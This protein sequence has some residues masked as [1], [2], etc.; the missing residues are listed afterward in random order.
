M[1][2]FFQFEL[3][4]AT[5]RIQQTSCICKAGLWHC[6]H[7]IGLF[8]TLAHYSQLVC[9]SVTKTKYKTSLPQ[10]WHVHSRVLGINPK[11]ATLLKIDK[12]KPPKL[13]HWIKDLLSHHLISTLSLL[14]KCSFGKYQ[15][16]YKQLSDDET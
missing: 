3:S 8:Y 9:R 14:C 13:W 5:E 1:S 11:P 15:S 16:N 10:T 2:L 6:S 12:I 4:S 7:L